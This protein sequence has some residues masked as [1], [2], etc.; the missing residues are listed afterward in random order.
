[1]DY[2]FPVGAEAVLTSDELSR[3]MLWLFENPAKEGEQYPD[4]YHIPI[5]TRIK[6]IGPNDA[7]IV[8]GPKELARKAYGLILK[9]YT[10]KFYT[11]GF[12]SINSVN[13]LGNFP[14][15]KE[16]EVSL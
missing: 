6:F 7:M 11:Y 10:E 4:D 1:M 9:L 8:S 14:K 16:E 3:M 15:K 12:R 13:T 5:G 2:T